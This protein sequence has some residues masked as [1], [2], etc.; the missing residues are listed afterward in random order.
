MSFNLIPFKTKHQI[1]FER[2]EF[3]ADSDDEFYYRQLFL[4]VDLFIEVLYDRD[5]ETIVAIRE[6]GNTE[7]LY[8]FCEDVDLNV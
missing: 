7:M 1:V 6:A 8:P 2:A 3:I 4:W 5:A